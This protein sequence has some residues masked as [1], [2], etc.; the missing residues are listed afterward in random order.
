M[1]S[2]KSPL[3]TDEVNAL[4]KRI[5]TEH[6]STILW[7]TEAKDLMQI[8]TLTG[9]I[10]MSASKLTTGWH[11]LILSD[12]LPQEQQHGYNLIRRTA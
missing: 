12:L 2:L 10:L 3:P 6:S 11:V 4:S 8:E 5:I 1:R 7:V 9:R